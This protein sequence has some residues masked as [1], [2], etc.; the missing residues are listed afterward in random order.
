[1]VASPVLNG[2]A[3]SPAASS[4]KATRGEVAIKN[5]ADRCATTLNVIK[6]R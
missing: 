2:H 5:E 6:K 4:S 1:L 3:E